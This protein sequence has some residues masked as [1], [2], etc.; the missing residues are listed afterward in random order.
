MKEKKAFGCL[1]FPGIFTALLTVMVVVVVGQVRGGALFIPGALNAQS[2]ATLGGVTS[3]AG[4]GGRCS[5]CHAYFWQTATMAERCVACHTDVAIQQ[6]DP[7]TLHGDQLNKNPGMTCRTC[8]PDHRGANAPLTDLAMADLSHEA[9]GYALT[10]HQT[11]TD[12]S[13]F[14]C[15]T[16]HV[17]GYSTFDQTACT[18]CHQQIKADFMQSHLQS[19]G[20]N[21]MACHDGIDTY[22]HSFD[23]GKVTFQLTGKHT[24]LDCGA[25]HTGAQGIADLKATHQDCYSCHA[26]DDAHKGQFGN[27]CGTCHSTNGWIPATFDHSLTKFPLTGAHVGLACTKCHSNAV[28]SVID[29]A[30]ASCHPDPSFHA[31]LFVG[32]ICDQCHTATAWSPATFSQAHPNSCGEVTCIDHERAACRDCHTVNLSTATCLKCHDSNNP[33]D[34]EGGG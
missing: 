3:H 4:L 33:G 10:A 11:Q 18:A 28:F 20:E 12:G 5:A 25:C 23:H 31:G 1:T 8:H 14:V 26:K 19:Y 13:P 9:F 24:Q 32:M 16:C 27:G 30:C 6:Q 2:G 17:N 15:N 29:I 34:G 7:S 21:C 22:G